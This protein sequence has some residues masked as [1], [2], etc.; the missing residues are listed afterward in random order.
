MKAAKSKTTSSIHVHQQS[1]PSGPF[2]QKKGQD[3]F[4]SSEMV[5]QKAAE[6]KSQ[7]F[8]SGSEPFFSPSTIQPKLKIGQPNDQYEQEADAKADE[9]VKN[10]DTNYA[11]MPNK[12]QLEATGKIQSKEEEEAVQSKEED[13]VKTK[14]TEED[15][16]QEKPIFESEGHADA[17]DSVQMK[18]D[19]TSTIA[20]PKTSTVV[21][22]PSIPPAIQ[23]KEEEIQEAPEQETE[24][25]RKPIFESNGEADQPDVQSKCA[26]CEQEEKVQK[27]DEEEVATK[28]EDAIQEKPIFESEGISER[29]NIA[30]VQSKEEE[31][32]ETA[33]PQTELHQKPIFESNGEPGEMSQVKPETNINQTNY[34]A[35]LI[36][37]QEEEVQETLEVEPELQKKPILDNAANVETPIQTKLNIGKPNDVH[38]VEADRVAKQVVEKISS[39]NTPNS[40]KGNQSNLSPTTSP[41]QSPSPSIS[42]KEE[43]IQEEREPAEKEL[44]TKAF[45]ASGNDGDEV[46]HSPH[47]SSSD[48][49]AP[50]LQMKGEG[51]SS[52][53]PAGLESTLNQSKGGGKPMERETQSEMEG[54]FGADF[55][56]VRI[57]TGSDSVKMNKG[58]RSQAFAHGNN[59]YF[60]EG[61]YQPHTRGGKELLAHE[62]TH[63]IQQGSAVMTKSLYNIQS[64]QPKIQGFDLGIPIPGF[65]RR[66]IKDVVENFVPGY[67][68]IEVMIGYD[69]ILDKDVPRNKENILKGVFSI[70]PFGTA[71]FNRLKEK[72][73]IDDAF[74]WIDDKLDKLDLNLD[75]I[76]NLV[77]R[78]WEEADFCSFRSC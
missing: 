40:E 47:G 21:A 69:F 75:R 15:T 51:N 68:L 76:L 60:N 42:T 39:A 10:L 8:F 74:V 73:I 63:T 77:E 65:V 22:T 12:D 35:P 16:I 29:G 38:E 4:G 13:E 20:E 53:V 5:M 59:V 71:L 45:A 66:D 3:G 44:Q 25:Q 9:V 23:S 36:Q 78:A 50:S 34:A 41:G 17:P 1:G 6:A 62:L 64:I 72:G 24:V 18:A 31:I 52:S 26:E 2:F 49:A 43:E 33:D 57:H 28:A 7:S 32:Q 61:R 58:L 54:A 37:Q 27:K 70:M 11:G 46:E 67:S 14:T 55:S 48:T 19:V 56:N 30:Q